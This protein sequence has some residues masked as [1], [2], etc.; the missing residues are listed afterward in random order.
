M[1]LAALAGMG[2][3]NPRAHRPS[4]FRRASTH[5]MPRISYSTMP[6]REHGEPQPRG[7][8]AILVRRSS[9][10]HD[11]DWLLHTLKYAGCYLRLMS[12]RRAVNDPNGRAVAPQVIAHPLKSRPTQIC[13]WSYE[14]HYAEAVLIFLARR[15]IPARTEHFECRPSPEVDVEIFQVLRVGADPP[16]R[17]RHP[18]IHRRCQILVDVAAALD[19]AAAVAGLY[20]YKAGFR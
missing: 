10:E 4:Y 20:P 17:R 14:T 3:A 8:L 12:L 11:A 6:F 2:R 9:R 13:R 15:G 16:I 19:P 18:A 7:L 1:R 5:A